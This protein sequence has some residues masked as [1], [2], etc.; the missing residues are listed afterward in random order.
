MGRL[1]LVGG[2]L[3]LI[4]VTAG[5]YYG[6]LLDPSEHTD[7]AL[8]KQLHQGSGGA[9]IIWHAMPVDQAYETITHQRTPFRPELAEGSRDE[10]DYLGALFTLTDAALAERVATQT[11]LE[12]GERVHPDKSTYDAVL[13]GIMALSTP[14]KLLPVEALVYQAIVEQRRY[15]QAWRKAGDRH[16]FDPRNPLVEGSHE[17][18]LKAYERLSELYGAGDPHNEQAFLD[19]LG[20]LDFF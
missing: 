3:L 1:I 2:L 13:S 19:H 14:G 17:K 5:V 12:A 7:Y 9:G 16:F 18:L 10:V 15:L 20:A 4:V 11:K 8:Q 6:G